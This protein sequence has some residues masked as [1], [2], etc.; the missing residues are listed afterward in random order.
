M[1][2]AGRWNLCLHGAESA[3]GVAVVSHHG[4]RANLAERDGRCRAVVPA[5]RPFRHV[6][7]RYHRRSEGPISPADR[8]K[9]GV[10]GDAPGLRARGI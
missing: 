2:S 6:L 8:L 3:E 9:R 1:R 4:C 7:R 5:H 10:A